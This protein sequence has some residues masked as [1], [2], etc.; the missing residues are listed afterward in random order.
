MGNFCTV[1]L[2]LWFGKVSSYKCAHPTPQTELE[3]KGVF[4]GK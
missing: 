4:V 3:V 1:D 2:I